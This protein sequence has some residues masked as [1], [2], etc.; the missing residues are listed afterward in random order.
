MIPNKKQMGYLIK[1]A[2]EIKENLERTRS[3]LFVGETGEALLR[4]CL[5][6]DPAI[7]ESE[8]YMET[9]FQTLTALEKA[10]C[11]G[12]MLGTLDGIKAFQKLH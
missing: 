5:G 10:V 11:L 6:F 12:K 4:N 9:Y 8:H 1:M 7:L 2:N 3:T